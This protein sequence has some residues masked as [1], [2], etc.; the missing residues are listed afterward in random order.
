MSD[1][2][3]PGHT[4]A[5]DPELSFLQLNFA[6][7]IKDSSLVSS[8]GMSFGAH[9]GSL[10]FFPFPH[11]V[12]LLSQCLPRLPLSLR[13]QSAPSKGALANGV[14]FQHQK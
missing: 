12:A 10:L 11:P 2:H 9:I 14:A 13:T 8:Y 4:A 5:L 7:N 3:L 6:L 1:R